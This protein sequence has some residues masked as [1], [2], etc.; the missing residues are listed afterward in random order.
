ML[1]IENASHTM[2]LALTA[3]RSWMAA[4]TSKISFDIQVRLAPDFHGLPCRSTQTVL[5][6]AEEVSVPFLNSLG[7]GMCTSFSA[8]LSEG[9]VNF[10]KEL[11]AAMSARKRA[12]FLWTSHD[13]T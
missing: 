4:L 13:L 2:A 8:K 10:A 3:Q 6:A 7:K 11:F 9:E 1:L 12:F 5:N